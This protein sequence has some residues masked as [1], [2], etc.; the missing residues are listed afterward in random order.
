MELD[1]FLKT[2]AGWRE[3]SKIEHMLPEEGRDGGDGS[4]QRLF[5]RL[6]EIAA[7]NGAHEVLEVVRPVRGFIDRTP[8]DGGSHSLVTP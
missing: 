6:D 8:D 5:A 2:Q 4:F 7:R 3:T 1:F